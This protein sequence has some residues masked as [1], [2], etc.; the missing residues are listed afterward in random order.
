MKKQ[1]YKITAVTNLQ[2]GSGSTSYSVVDNLIQRDPASGIPCIHGSSMKGAVK[3]YFKYQ[4][5]KDDVRIASI[6]GDNDNPANYKFISAQLV[7]MP[8]RS[9]VQ[10]YFHATCPRV[11]NEA[12]TNAKRL[13][14]ELNFDG[15]TEGGSCRLKPKDG[16]PILFRVA[17][18]GMIIEDFEEFQVEPNVSENLIGSTMDIVLLSDADFITMTNNNHLPVIA[19]NRMDGERNLWYEQVLPR[20]S[21]LISYVFYA[22][23]SDWTEFSHEISE[24]GNLIHIGANATVGYGFTKFEKL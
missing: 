3:E 15:L 1:T 23:D 10:S 13:G 11:I 24:A 9:N 17:D 12:I 8:L 21:V 19:R 14:L 18:K 22:D 2:A 4:W 6:F 16:V 7:A 20:E 5:G